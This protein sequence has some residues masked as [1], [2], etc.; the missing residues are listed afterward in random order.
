MSDL[1]GIG[2]SQFVHI[3]DVTTNI[4]HLVMGPKRL[5]LQ[6]HQKKIVGPLPCIVV[7]PGSYCVIADPI[8]KYKEGEVCE[9]RYGHKEIR[10]HQEPFPLYPGETLEGAPLFM[11]S[12][13]GEFGKRQYL[14]AMRPLPVVKAN[15]AVRL[16]AVMDHTSPDGVNRIAGDMWQYNGP[17]TYKPCPEAMMV[18][19]IDA[20][21]L[22]KGAALRLTA[23][24]DLTDKY[25]KQRVAGEQWL[26]KE[27]GAYLP[28]VYEE[29]DGIV[30]PYQLTPYT[31]LHLRALQNCTDALGKQRVAGDEWLVT[32]L[33]S[34]A[35]IMEIGEEL[36][37]TLKQTV[38]QKGQYCVINN[39]VDRHGKPQ[40]GKKELRVGNTSFFLHP[41]ESIE[42][43]IKEQYLLGEDEALVLEAVETFTDNSLPGGKTRK[44]GDRWM[45][46]GPKSYIPPVQVK[47]VDQGDYQVIRKAIP[48][49]ENEGIYVRNLQTG[50]V[51]MVLG[52]RSYLLNE[53][54]MLWEK[55]LDPLVLSIL[56]NGGGSGEGDIRKLAYFEQSIDPEY[57][58]D[59]PRDKTKVVRYRCPHNTAVQVYKYQEKTARVVFGPDMVI[60]GPHE[61]FNVLSLSAGKPKVEN[62]LKTI[63]LMLGPDYIT[64]IFQVETA[65]HARLQIKIAFN[66]HFEFKH[67]DPV[68]ESSIFSVPDFIGFACRQIG[69]R[70]RGAVS[71]VKFDEFHRNSMQLL[72]AGVFGFNK[73]GTLKDKLVF[74]AN[75]LVITNVDIQAIEPVD[76]T[77]RTSLLKS[78]QMAIEIATQSIQR[79]AGHDA[80]C[81]EQEARGLLERQKLINEQENEK[82]R[83]FL[84]ELQASTAA[85]ESCGQAKAEAQAQAE[86]L[87][88]EG[89]SAIEAARLKAQAEEILASSD[90]DTTQMLRSSELDYQREMSDMEISRTKELAD[91]DVSKFS[92]MVNALGK[93]IIRDIASSG[94][95][96]QVEL[97][98]SLGMETTIFTDGNSPIN[99]FNVAEGLVATQQ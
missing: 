2:P 21:V 28:G 3:L 46:R 8:K 91:I 13:N 43:G 9:L 99:L 64:D 63:C 22:T 69:S 16:K 76:S 4:T 86:R 51:N 6:T 78:V 85:V 10:F 82:A 96:F 36:I 14:K 48:L 35:Y 15:Q 33:D 98:Q 57:A 73:D 58:G 40:F 97:L 88:I 71:R 53:H 1:I 25:G 38:L 70:V 50:D 77:M 55:E 47:E 72:K 89:L 31:G 26:V 83:C 62:A 34:E 74:D 49:G 37:C 32:G 68:E 7:P 79:T 60:L 84:H 18:A 95:K 17:L 52:P 19:I 66:N 92:Q 45:I 27:Q 81:K 59:K 56:R 42:G 44:P 54:E 5:M 61:D 20:S 29:V 12:A 30:E 67:G 39:P 75:K 24:R 11:A 93:N 87:L 23:L 41:G 90:L 65:D 80:A 94:P